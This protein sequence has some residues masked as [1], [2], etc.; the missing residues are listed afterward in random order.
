MTWQPGSSAAPLD[1]SDRISSQNPV[2]RA[3]CPAAERRFHRSINHASLCYNP[4]RRKPD[5]PRTGR[6]PNPRPV[7]QTA[8]VR[9]KGNAG[10]TGAFLFYNPALDACLIGSLNQFRYP[11]K[12]IRFMMQVM[13]MLWNN[14]K[15]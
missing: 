11:A 8:P 1:S 6:T 15:T 14:L 9:C 13:N 12:G 10:S 4:R 5:E 7:E 3:D 2:R